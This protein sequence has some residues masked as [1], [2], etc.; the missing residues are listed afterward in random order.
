M[1]IETL[2]ADYERKLTLQRYSKSSILNYKS[3]VKAFLQVASRKFSSPDELGATEIEKYVF[4]KINKHAVGHSYQRMIVASIDKFYEMVVGIKLN[5]KHLY[6][7]RKTHALPK[8]LGPG[9]VKR[10]IDS[11]AN[12]KH[13]CIIK[14]L[15][16]CG[17]RLSELLNLRIT[18]I[19]SG[20]MVVHIRNSKGNKDRV[21][22]LSNQLLEELRA[23]FL[24]YKPQEYLIEGQGGGLYSEKSVQNVVKYAAVKAGIKKQVTP[25]TLRHSFA[26][27]LLENGTDIRYIQQLLGHSSVKTTEI[28]THITDI[29]KSKIKSPL[30]LIM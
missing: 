4:W 26:T 27:H 1:Q 6:P 2:L 7:S 25:H 22:M 3:A 10:M 19:D 30:D 24:K 9:E 13:K 17:L 8:Y 16:G 15:Y 21:V 18:D 12:Q 14:L 29:A 11:T 5:L 23:Y 20:S 28:Y